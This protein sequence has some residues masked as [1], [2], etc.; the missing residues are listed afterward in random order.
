MPEE[1]NLQ[2]NDPKILEA[3][4]HYADE[5]ILF[6]DSE[7][8]YR[9]VRI[10][11]GYM[12]KTPVESPEFKLAYEEMVLKMKFIALDR[13]KTEE[14]AE[15][16][17]NNFSVLFELGD[18]FELGIYNLWAKVRAKLVAEPIYTGRD[19]MRKKIRE[20]I[21]ASEQIL[22]KEGL[23]LGGVKVKG[24]VKNWLADYNH[25]VGSGKIETLQLVQY[26]TNSPNTKSLS[27]ESKKR[28]DYLLKFYEKIKL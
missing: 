16:L 19:E 18:L 15:L 13:L 28:L 26:V 3:M 27:A 23:T 9:L 5:A 8:A 7:A 2:L 17:Q 25:A 11:P 6:G 4:K 24:T 20:A 10:L 21:L 22:T 14:I 12:A 1:T